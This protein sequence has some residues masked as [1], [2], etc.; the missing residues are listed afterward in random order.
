MLACFQLRPINHQHQHGK[1]LKAEFLGVAPTVL[2]HNVTQMI[3]WTLWLGSCWSSL[4]LLFVGRLGLSPGLRLRWVAGKRLN[5][6]PGP[7]SVITV[8]SELSAGPATARNEN[9]LP[10]HLQYRCFLL[11]PFFFFLL[12][13]Y[14]Y[15]LLWRL[16]MKKQ[17]GYYIYP[18]YQVPTHTPVQ[19]LSISAARCHRC[20]M[21][22][23]CATLS[24]LW[25]PTPCVLNIIPISP[26]LP[27]SPP[28]LPLPSP[29]V[30]TSP[31]W[32]LWVCCCFVLPSVLLHCYTP[33]MREIIWHLSFSA[34]L[35]SLSI[36]SSSS[37]Y[38][39][40]T[41]FWIESFDC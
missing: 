21:C 8:R 34:W 39:I 38:I 20:P 28:T 9:T 36:I 23:L 5:L 15:T 17:C 31:S 11:T 35:I 16:H 2:V 32:S 12:R 4:A 29:L 19:S 25:S 10:A 14:W 24:S 7:S 30:T 13:Y 37:I 41:L 33:Q 6:W 3:L 18:Y 1:P 40:N 27:P 22:L 26:H